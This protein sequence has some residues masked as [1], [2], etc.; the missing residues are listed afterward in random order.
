MNSNKSR[1][2][3]MTMIMRSFVEMISS[4]KP[5]KMNKMMMASKKKMET[6]ASKK[7][8]IKMISGMKLDLTTDSITLLPILTY[9]LLTLKRLSTRPLNAWERSINSKP[10]SWVESFLL[11]SSTTQSSLMSDIDV[12]LKFYLIQIQYAYT[13]SSRSSHSCFFFCIQRR[14]CS[15]NFVS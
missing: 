7:K 11:H 4:M 12:V 10:V 8:R 2:V 15:L 1:N 13:K 6:M 5:N 14:N 9:S 3:T